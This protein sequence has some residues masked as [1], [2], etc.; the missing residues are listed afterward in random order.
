M[1]DVAVI[2]SL[3]F[4]HIFD[5][6]DSRVKWRLVIEKVLL[7]FENVGVRFNTEYFP[8]TKLS[9]KCLLRLSKMGVAA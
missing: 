5:Q 9:K 4:M 1:F 8:K 2:C 3:K 6:Q 7:F